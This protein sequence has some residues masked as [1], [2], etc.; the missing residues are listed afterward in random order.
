[1]FDVYVMAMRYLRQIWRYRLVAVLVALPVAGFGWFT[2]NQMADVYRADTRLYVDTSS[3]LNRLLAGVALDSSDVDQEF[4][5]VARRSLLSRPNLERIARETDLELDILSPEDRDRLLQGLARDIRVRGESTRG[6]RGASDNLFQ[7]AYDHRDPERALE[8]VRAVHDVFIESVLGLSR[9]D[10]ERM[11]TF[12]DRQIAQYEARLEEAEE[13]RKRFRQ[14]NA[15]LLPGEGQNYFSMLNAARE[16]L[17]EGE[18]DLRRA[19]RIRE[20]LRQQLA[21]LSRDTDA[22]PLQVGDMAG[23]EWVDARPMS[24]AA[25]V[26]TLEE[27]LYELRIRYTEAHPDVVAAQRRL[28]R[29][30]ANLA[31]TTGSGEPA[32]DGAAADQA[33]ISNRMRLQDLQAELARAQA[34]VASE[35]AAVEEYRERMA[36]LEGAVNTIPEVEAEL[37]RLNRD[38]NI[39]RNQYEQLVSRREAA[40]MS[41][42]ADLTAD[43]SIFQVIEPPHVSSQPVGPDRPRLATMVMGGALAAGGGLAFLFS[44]IRPT[45][46]DVNQL[47]DVGG[48]H[49]LG[50]VGIVRSPREQWMHRMSFVVYG[51][52]FAAFI[53]AYI[54]VLYFAAF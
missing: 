16:R 3:M 27:Q 36:R 50:R 10:T 28:E 51:L 14:A 40:S 44:L 1:M 54:A 35:R 31:A 47:R 2:I 19:E 33:A 6:G 7:L 48:V 15:G 8:V 5:R 25:Q 17:R 37:T 23:E 20:D 39:L 32:A 42:E 45:V 49:V 26:R 21:E 34:Q 46:G 30:R 43:E 9:R 24:S 11:D 41:R 29:A 38:Y 12:L 22:L 18:L 4:L 52:I 53:A 13:R